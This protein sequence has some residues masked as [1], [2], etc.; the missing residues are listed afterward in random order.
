MK[1]HPNLPRFSRNFRCQEWR[2]LRQ[3][4]WGRRR[5]VAGTLPSRGAAAAGSLRPTRH[6]SRHGPLNND[7]ILIQSGAKM[8][9]VYYSH[10]IDVISM[11]ICHFWIL[12]ISYDFRC[13]WR[14]WHLPH[15]SATGANK[16]RTA[17]AA[18]MCKAVGFQTVGTCEFAHWKCR[19]FGSMFETLLWSI[20]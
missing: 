3:L 1:S 9:T 6:D 16:L 19:C 18:S 12:L 20:Q 15:N 7:I 13:R 8:I 5:R 10:L 17:G 4:P 11:P 2:Q 14:S